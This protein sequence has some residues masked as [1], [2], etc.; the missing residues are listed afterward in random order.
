[1]ITKTKQL[2]LS[3]AIL[4]S[5]SVTTVSLAA[6]LTAS[7]TTPALYFDDTSTAADGREWG[8]AGRD[9]F[10]GL[11]DYSSNTYVLNINPSATSSN[12]FN[13]TSA[14]DI[15][16][17]NG[18][19][20]IDRSIRSMGLGTTIPTAKLHVVGDIKTTFSG[21][22]PTGLIELL[23]LSANNTTAGQFS[24]AGF[25]MENAKAGFSWAFR[26]QENTGG[27][28]ASKQGTGAK[29]FE[30]RNTTTIASLVELHLANG[31]S[32]VGGQWLNASSRSYKENINKLSSEDAMQA[33][34][35]LQSVTYQFKRDKSK[36]QRVGFIAEDV[37]A[38]LATKDKKT[39]DPLQIIAVLTK[40]VQVQGESFQAEMKSK[41]ARIVE[42]EA[43]ISKLI[44][45]QERMAKTMASDLMQKATFMTSVSND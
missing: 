31:A 21:P 32:N 19:V 15:N 40:A 6:D 41:D 5:M 28:A 3:S 36:Q 14:G 9:E 8:F 10:F 25:S 11:Y 23:K 33:L 7:D 1:M 44:L 27:F 13:I 22:N 26:T 4:A 20:F 35:G 16:L 39:V 29:E 24:D 45:L 37:P 2:L 42:M 18:S 43:K 38:L 30:V 12:S 17:G 34:K